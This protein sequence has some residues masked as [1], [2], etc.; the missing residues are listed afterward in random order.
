MSNVLECDIHFSHAEKGRLTTGPAAPPGR[1]P[2]VAR[3]LDLAHRLDRLVRE[4]KVTDFAA[5]ARRGQVSRARVSQLLN[6]LLLAPDIQEEILFLPRVER[7]RDPVL[8]CQLQ[9][10]ALEPNWAKQ[11]RL[12]RNLRSSARCPIM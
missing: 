2:R 8:L 1:W 4:G 5:L 3:W 10:I 9:P 7:G 12:W 11:R 6:L